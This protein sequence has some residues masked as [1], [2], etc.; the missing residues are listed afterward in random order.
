M[1]CDSLLSCCPAFRG[2]CCVAVAGI[3]ETEKIVIV[4]EVYMMQEKWFVTAK[5][6]DFAAI[7][8]KFHISPV[9]ARI[10]RNRDVITEEEVDYFLNGTLDRLHNPREMYDME[11]G[12]AI[13]AGKI[14]D[15]K[16]IRIIGDYDVDGICATYILK[17]GLSFLG[18]QVSTVIPHRVK[19]GYGLNGHLIEEAVEDGVDTILTCDNGIAAY[20]EIALAKQYGMTVVVTDHHEVPYEMVSSDFSEENSEE[21]M[22]GDQG[23]RVTKQEILPPAD[24]VIDPKQERCR[25]PYPGI[26]GALVAYKLIQLLFEETGLKKLRSQIS[27]EQM[28]EVQRELLEFAAIATICDVMELLDENRIVVK[29]GLKYMENSRNMGLRT[30][31]ELCG[32][33]GSKLTNY[34]V[35]FVIGPCMNATGRLDSAVRALELFETAEKREAVRLATDLKQMNESRKTMTERGVEEAVSRMEAG[36][37]AGD[38]VLVIYLRDC[39]ESIAGIIAGRIREKYGKPVLIVTDGEDGL[40]GSGRSIEA[41]SMYEGLHNAEQ[42]LSK[43]GGH[44]MAAGFSLPREN[45]HKL[46]EKLNRDCSLKEEDFVQKIM[47]DVPMPVSYASMEFVEELSLLEPF[48]N[49]N[50]KPVFAQ[51]NLEIRSCVVRGKNR[52]VAGFIL[53]DENGYEVEGIFFGEAD[54]FVREVKEHSG[55]I[56]VI[57]Y[58]DINEFRGK[59]TL[60]MVVTHYNFS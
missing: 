10:I 48:G 50:P 44:K 24:A 26:C 31:I 60:Q 47:I 33:E 35:G 1:F 4:S 22:R 42:L 3:G 11:K 25:Y 39:H 58:P 30:L 8:E 19:D 27:G 56:N 38:K 21:D 2:D 20:R 5:K 37:F 43:Y 57:Y 32:L 55:R 17:R 51:K 41:Y 28:K 18:A 23:E 13:L 12:A 9:L 29:Y 59:R 36:E 54:K 34:H 52:N 40:K 46:R 49:G 53:R 7:G 16:P 6:A 45:L 14:E 15:G